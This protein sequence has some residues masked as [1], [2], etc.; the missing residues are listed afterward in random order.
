M[1]HEV[2]IFCPVYHQL[3][4]LDV[5]PVDCTTVNEHFFALQGIRR[6][7]KI[8]AYFPC[9]LRGDVFLP[10]H[11][12][13]ERVVVHVTSDA[14]ILFVQRRGRVIVSIL[15]LLLLGNG[16]GRNMFTHGDVQ[17]VTT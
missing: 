8:G 1:I 15:F 14:V 12:V 17:F 11:A 16:R 3:Q 4:L 6:L 5:G 7:L 2:N 10:P 9:M 13:H